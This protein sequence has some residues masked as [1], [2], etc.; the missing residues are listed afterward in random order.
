MESMRKP[1][2]Y[3]KRSLLSQATVCGRAIPIPA[4]KQTCR[5]ANGICLLHLVAA[6]AACSAIPSTNVSTLLNA[7]G[8]MHNAT[9]VLSSKKQQDD[10]PRQEI[11]R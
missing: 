4:P 2:K 6:M 1:S 9:G 5:P 7:S 8:I 3:V 10:P 11:V